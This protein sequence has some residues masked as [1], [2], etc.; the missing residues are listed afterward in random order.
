MARR[1]ITFLEVVVGVALLGVVTA[2][3][4]GTINFATGIQLRQ[5]RMLACSEVANRLVLEYL[6]DPTKLP[7]PSKT[8]DYGPPEAPA[9]FRWEYREDSLLVQD[10]LPEA[11]D[12][13]RPSTLPVDRFRQV[14]VRVWLSEESGG[15]RFPD[16]SVPLV[17][18]SRM[19]DPLAPRNPDSFMNMMNN[20]E[21]FQ[22]FMGSFMGVQTTRGGMPAGS[23]IT[24]DRPQR[25]QF[26]I[27]GVR[28]DGAFGRIGANGRMTGSGRFGQMGGGR[29][30]SGNP[31]GVQPM[32]N[33][34]GGGRQ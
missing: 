24:G 11:R 16:D 25:G 5:A 10:A 22:Q 27:G 23:G 9:K 19:V 17:T 29:F 26:G 4:L 28:P 13:S 20:P 34:R 18:L 7:D 33:T 15:S 2:A 32:G 3:M 8:V 1:G 30:G 14:T 31:S 6:D 12:A 21:L